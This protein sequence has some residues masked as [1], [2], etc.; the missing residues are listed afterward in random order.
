MHTNTT[1]GAMQPMQTDANQC[2]SMLGG[3]AEPM[4][5]MHPMQTNAAVYL[6]I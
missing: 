5:P 2:K 3:R 1:N 4:Q 6:L